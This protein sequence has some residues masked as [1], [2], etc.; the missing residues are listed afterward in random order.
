MVVKLNSYTLS[1]NSIDT[2]RKVLGMSRDIKKEIG[3]T[4]CSMQDNFITLRGWHVGKERSASIAR[5]CNEG[6]KYVGYYHTHPIETSKATGVDLAKCGDSKIICV[7]GASEQ[8]SQQEQTIDSA[9]CYIW[10]DKV[11]SVREGEQILTDALKGR[12]EPRN[13]EHRQHFNC[14]NTIGRYGYKE[15]GLI[16]EKESLVL[17]PMRKLSIMKELGE[18]ETLVDKEVDKYYKKIGIELRRD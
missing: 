14:S 13:P 11:I 9:N 17:A 5:K 10:K 7:G 3:I 1:D 16:N 12:K 18:L 15:L 6:E 2:M 4:M 8:R